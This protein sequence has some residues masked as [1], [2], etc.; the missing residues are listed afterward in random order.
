MRRL[1]SLRLRRPRVS[2][3]VARA[4][5]FLPAR[6]TVALFALGLIGIALI[7]GL[8]LQA[9][10]APASAGDAPTPNHYAAAP[11]QAG[12]NG[13][14][15]GNNGG[16]DPGEDGEDDGAGGAFAADGA[17]AAAVDESVPLEGW[18]ASAA[19]EPYDLAVNIRYKHSA[20]WS[21][22]LVWAENRGSR[23]A[24]GVEVL[25]DRTNPLTGKVY[26]KFQALGGS[27]PDGVLD[28]SDIDYVQ[29]DSGSGV[30]RIGTLPAGSRTG[31]RLRPVWEWTGNAN[32]KPPLTTGTALP[33]RVVV[34]LTAAI[35]T[36]RRRDP[37]PD[38]NRDTAGIVIRETDVLFTLLL[39]SEFTALL[40]AQAVNLRPANKDGQAV[41]FTLKLEN[42][43]TTLNKTH[44][45]LSDVTLDVTLSGLKV[46]TAPTTTELNGTTLPVPGFRHGQ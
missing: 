21:L 18:S 44:A 11:Q 24:H 37:L 19:G 40:E 35:S 23:D 46:K 8:S 9:G 12:D 5:A 28:F 26:Y 2:A 41:D 30:W 38:N 10:N 25:L 42:P 20:D 31:A 34:P 32:D 14:N 3:P 7:L 1:P 15:E 29:R 33:G 36:P 13:N 17:V 43:G 16:G 45:L 22:F 6:R 4:A 39:A 27:L